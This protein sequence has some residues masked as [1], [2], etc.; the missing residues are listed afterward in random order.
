MGMEMHGTETDSVRALVEQAGTG[1][2]RRNG[3]L[4]ANVESTPG[5]R[6]WD[7]GLEN[8]LIRY[9]QSGANIILIVR[10]TPE[11]ARQVVEASC[12]PVKDSEFAAFARF[13]FDAVSRYSVPPYNVKYWEI[14]NEPDVVINPSDS[15]FGCWGRDDPTYG[16]TYYGEM[17]KVVYP[18]IKAANP[19]AQ[20]LVG[21]LL[22][23]CDPR[24]P[25][26]C[27]N[28]VP[29]L[30]LQGIL[31]AGAG[32]SFD[33]ISYHAYDYYMGGLGHYGNKNWGS[34]W[35]TT[36]PVAAA[37]MNFLQSQLASFGIQGKYL[38][39]T[40]S[41]LISYDGVCDDTCEL[42]KAYYAAQIYTLTKALNM[43]ASIWF[44]FTGWRG[45]GMVGPGPEFAPLPVYQAYA[46]ASSQLANTTF[47]RTV[48]NFP[49]V[50]IY[51]LQRGG[52]TLWVLW[53]LDGE[54]HPIQLEHAPQGAW[55][56]LGQAE[57]VNGME[58]TVTIKPIYILMNP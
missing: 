36:G 51:E 15:P 16:G 3:L 55:D 24:I 48:D 49:G 18:Q 17:L 25:E 23:D 38:I 30:Y 52:E 6:L 54:P 50:K 28:P 22:L 45:S 5:E 34:Q 11:W 33:G 14:W 20:V 19:E 40:E 10:A 4:W 13:L 44:S 2:I 32:N 9:A 21:G 12:G 8:E 27:T 7:A 29:A 39:N 47:T 58:I 57:P 35:N 26:A 41:A 1:W 56:A 37:K 31:E 42:S 46:I 43:P 53:S